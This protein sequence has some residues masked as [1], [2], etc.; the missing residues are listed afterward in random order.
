MGYLQVSKDWVMG[1]FKICVQYMPNAQIIKETNVNKILA[2]D[3]GITNHGLT[4]N[5]NHN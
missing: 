2:L 5:D 1:T 4:M 3:K